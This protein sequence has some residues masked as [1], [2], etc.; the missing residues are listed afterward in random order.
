VIV[1]S[2]GSPKEMAAML[3]AETIGTL[4]VGMTS[5]KDAKLRESAI[6]GVR[7]LGRKLAS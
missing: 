5:G 1:R 3:G 2:L 6:N 4:N 7:M